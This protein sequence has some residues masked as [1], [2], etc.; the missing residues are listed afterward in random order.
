MA[1]T[2][3]GGRPQ[4][5]SDVIS[6]RVIAR[7]HPRQWHGAYVRD[8]SEARSPLAVVMS[9]RRTVNN[10]ASLLEA[11]AYRLMGA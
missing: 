8:R 5:K 11:R 1:Q 9:I 3:H 10:P 4:V 7:Y 6:S 2:A